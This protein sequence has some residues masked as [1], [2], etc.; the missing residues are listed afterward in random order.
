MGQIDVAAATAAY[1]NRAA[2]PN[3]ATFLPSWR[4]RSAAVRAACGAHLDVRYGT[5]P[6]ATLDFFATGAPAA[7]TL[8]FFHGGYWQWNGKDD[9]AFIAESLLALPLNVALVGY[10]LAPEASLDEI[11]TEACAAVA[12]LGEHARDFGASRDVFVGG[13]SAG[14]H[15]A[16]LAAHHEAV[17]GGFA[18]SGLFDLEPLLETSLNAVLHMDREQARRCSP[19]HRPLARVPFDVAVGADELPELRRQSERF[20]AARAAAGLPG[21]YTAFPGLNHYTILDAFADPN[22]AVFRALTASLR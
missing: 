5:A 4:E 11:V 13:W 22:S 3:S 12:W 2:V 15:L 9:F 10:S 20:G 16:A 14:G 17:R 6:R 7:P 18:I 19:L 1:D 21:A 8:A